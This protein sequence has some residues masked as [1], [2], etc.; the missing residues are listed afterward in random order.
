M[1]GTAFDIVARDNGDYY[2][3]VGELM[4]APS[5]VRYLAKHPDSRRIISDIINGAPAHELRKVYGCGSSKITA[6]R[7]LLRTAWK[8]VF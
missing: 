6:I 7:N 8:E 4:G 1:Q 5:V 3:M 2:K